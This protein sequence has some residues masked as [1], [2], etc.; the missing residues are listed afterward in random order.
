MKIRVN[1]VDSGSRWY[2]ACKP[3]SLPLSPAFIGKFTRG[4][5]AVP[6]DSGGALSETLN[7]LS[8]ATT[9][10]GKLYWLK[11]TWR[12]ANRELEFSIYNYLKK[13]DVANLPEIVCCGDVTENGAIQETENHSFLADSGADWRRPTGIIR[14]MIH[15]RSVQELLIPLWHV[16]TAR[17]LLRAG[18]DA[19]LST[20]SNLTSVILSDFRFSHC[21]RISSRMSPTSGHQHR[22]HHANERSKQW[23]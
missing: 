1:S 16:K 11:D 22:Q 23:N 17:E 18:R 6:I 20:K 19:L 8:S 5:I 4:F 9:E 12:P 10:S 21:R 13:R 15:H 3:G 2:L 7:E 14:H